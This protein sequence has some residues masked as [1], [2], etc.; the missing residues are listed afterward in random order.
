MTR[1]LQTSHISDPHE[2]CLS[3]YIMKY[4]RCI[5]PTRSPNTD[6]C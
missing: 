2:S 4:L 1:Q 6:T 5:R 3:K